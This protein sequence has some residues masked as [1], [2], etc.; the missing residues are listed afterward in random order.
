MANI[1]SLNHFNKE[2]IFHIF[3]MINRIRKARKSILFY[4]NENSFLPLYCEGYS[5]TVFSRITIPLE[6]EEFIQSPKIKRFFQVEDK[7]TQPFL[8][9]TF[10]LGNICFFYLTSDYEENR[11]EIPLSWLKEDFFKEGNLLALKK[12]THF[13]SRCQNSLTIHFINVDYGNSFFL[14]ILKSEAALYKNVMNLFSSH[15][16]VIRIDYGKVLVLSDYGFYPDPSAM[17]YHISESLRPLLPSNA[18]LSVKT[19]LSSPQLISEKEIID[20][21]FLPKTNS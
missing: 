19:L 1:I 21:F 2:Q 16:K 3:R 13:L 4:G 5:Y 15:S 12:S 20:E 6:F 11:Q 7:P 14:N 17:Q 18:N 9:E 10:Y 8:W